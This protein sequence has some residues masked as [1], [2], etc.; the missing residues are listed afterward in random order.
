MTMSDMGL[1]ALCKIFTLPSSKASRAHQRLVTNLG[2][3]ELVIGPLNLSLRSSA[4]KAECKIPANFA[5]RRRRI[6]VCRHGGREQACR[7]AQTERRSHDIAPN[8]F[9]VCS[10][11]SPR[12]AAPGSASATAAAASTA[13][14][15]AGAATGSAGSSTIRDTNTVYRDC[16]LHR[17]R[18]RIRHPR[19][20]GY[21]R[22]RSR[23]IA[24]WN[25][26]SNFESGAV[27]RNLLGPRYRVRHTQ[28][29]FG[30]LHPGLR[31]GS[32]IRPPIRA[33]DRDSAPPLKAAHASC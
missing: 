21:R 11:G 25:A 20:E 31:R 9:R 6:A 15:G 33:R 23:S 28:T 2:N 19:H 24:A 22:S 14:R 30:R 27:Q 8:R 12:R 17:Y 4:P 5:R 1:F 18:Y 10:W 29:P 7:N 26:H 16:V 3:A 13:D 32:A